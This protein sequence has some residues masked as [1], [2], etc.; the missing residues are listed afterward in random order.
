M[1]HYYTPNPTAEHDL[2]LIEATLR[3]RLLRFYTDSGVF[4]KTAVDFGSE[5]LINTMAI[6]TAAF[7][8]DMGCGWG[9]I[10]IS[11]ALL[12][13]AG[14]VLMADVNTRALELAERNIKLNGV[15]NAEV[16]QSD[17]FASL[18]GYR[19]DVIL[20][21]PPIRAGKNVVHSIFSGAAECLNPGGSLWVVMQK[22]QGAPSAEKKL[23]EL[24]AQVHTRERSKG[25][26][27]YEAVK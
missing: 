14:R 9:P 13:P 23:A 19:F 24:F 6:P 20:T 17:V 3:G 4:S 16:I 15:E 1:S 5:L 12:N 21:N 7:V 8:L 11:A 2:K 25:Y 22:K 18:S 26:Y 27:I 10:G